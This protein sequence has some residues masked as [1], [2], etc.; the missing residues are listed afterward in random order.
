MLCQENTKDYATRQISGK[1]AIGD[2]LLSPLSSLG[3]VDPRTPLMAIGGSP[4]VRWILGLRES[5]GVLPPPEL[6]PSGAGFS[7]FL[8]FFQILLRPS[9]I[10]ICWLVSW[11]GRLCLSL[12]SILLLEQAS[13]ATFPVTRKLAGKFFPLF[14]L[15]VKV[16]RS[17]GTFFCPCSL[18][19]GSPSHSSFL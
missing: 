11:V 18:L 7:L 3:L 16:D 19:L 9:G 1:G 12:A 13:P 5:S 17:S 10:F 4:E 15:A 6:L 14:L 8:S 2:R